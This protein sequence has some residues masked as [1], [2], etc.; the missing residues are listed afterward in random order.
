M[1]DESRALQSPV[2]PD[3]IASEVALAIEHHPASLQAPLR[4]KAATNLVL[5]TGPEGLK[6]QSHHSVQFGPLVG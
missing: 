5:I 3:A 6:E 1:P 4:S 2:V